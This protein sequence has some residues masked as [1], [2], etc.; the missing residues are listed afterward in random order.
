[1]SI[2][3]LTNDHEVKKIVT[4]IAPDDRHAFSHVEH[5]E[6]LSTLASALD[7]TGAR[8]LVLDL[9]LGAGALRALRG[10][11]GRRQRVTAVVIADPA[12]PEMSAEALRLGALDVLGRPIRHADLMV[13]LGHAR[14]FQD[15]T[16]RAPRSGPVQIADGFHSVSP[17]MR[18]VREIV[19]RV[20][21]SRCGVMLVGEPGTG[22]EMV[23]RSIHR[24]SRAADQPFVVV[25]C[26]YRGE[27]TKSDRSSLAE[28]ERELFQAVAQP[29][30]ELPAAASDSAEAVGRGDGPAGA[31]RTVYLRGIHRMAPVVQGTL[32]RLLAESDSRLGR[33]RLSPVR[34]LAGAGPEIL[35]AVDR[36]AFR[37]DLFE[38]L[39]VVRIDLPEL[40]RRPQDIPMLA[41]HFL[42]HACERH[43]T[44]P[45]VFSPSAQ[46]LLAALPWR[47]NAKELQYLA[48]RLAVLVQRGVVLQEDV[49]EQVHLDAAGTR[50]ATGGRLRD[51]REQFEREFIAGVLQRHRGRMGVA[52]E[53]LGIER[54]NLYRKMKQLGIKGR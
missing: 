1:M 52:A 32:E 2:L 31:G 16:F 46:N 3:F 40:R 27:S 35:D 48:E 25:N 33:D 17:Q 39:A 36:G 53:E 50:G 10:L 26:A 51:A 44:S 22:K 18:A 9:A 21:P 43:G 5:V 41:T 7:R 4:A 8:T 38:R 12:H 42:K 11:A 15:V 13:A 49:L 54:T 20:A 45:K 29:A 30:F 34:I 23:A 14:E 47:G 19:E 28:F 24:L 6:S 37:R